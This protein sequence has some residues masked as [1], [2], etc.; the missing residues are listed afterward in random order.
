MQN[1]SKIY[2]LLQTFINKAKSQ[3]RLKIVQG[4]IETFQE[5]T[6]APYLNGHTCDERVFT[7]NEFASCIEAMTKN[8]YRYVVFFFF[9]NHAKRL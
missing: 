5:L 7:N 3:K 4:K 2:V 1:F 6:P 8:N 9:Y